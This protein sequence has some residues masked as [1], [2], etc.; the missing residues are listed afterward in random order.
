MAFTMLQLNVT[1]TLGE[2]LHAMRRRLAIPLDVVAQETK[3]QPRYLRAIEEN[4]WETLPEPIYTRNFLRA[5]AQYLGA[6]PEYFLSRF[7]QERAS[8]DYLVHA[9]KPRQRLRRFRLFVFSHVWKFSFLFIA[10]ATLFTY[11][12]FQVHTIVT[13]PEVVLYSPTE[14]FTTTEPTIIVSGATLEASTITVNGNPTLPSES[15][16]FRAEVTLERGLNVITIEGRK[17]YSRPHVIHRA[18]IFD[19]QVGDLSFR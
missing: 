3:I 12:G 19:S 5:Y 8:C 10:L 16:T 11:I 2:E 13:P 9:Q 14:G 4:D 7:E 1:H 15:G 17:R 18:I 6:D